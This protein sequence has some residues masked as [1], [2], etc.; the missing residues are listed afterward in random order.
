MR[1][2][3]ERMGLHGEATADRRFETPLPDQRNHF[4]I[5]FSSDDLVIWMLNGT[6]FPSMSKETETNAPG[7]VFIVDVRGT[8]MSFGL[9]A[10]SGTSAKAFDTRQ[11]RGSRSG[12]E[13]S[14]D[15]FGQLRET[16]KAEE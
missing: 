10:P 16:Q 11:P 14:R 4:V 7:C 6:P 15:R 5:E 8:E 2:I 9:V 13:G 1:Q 12:V 3:D